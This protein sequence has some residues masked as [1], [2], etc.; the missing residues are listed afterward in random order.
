[1]FPYKNTS[2]TNVKLGEV[3]IELTC[4]IDRPC[5]VVRNTCI[6]KKEEL[7]LKQREYDFQFKETKKG[8][9]RNS[10]INEGGKASI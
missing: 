8:K 5:E 9:E 3:R 7:F 6:R 10:E 2:Q 4:Q 1:M